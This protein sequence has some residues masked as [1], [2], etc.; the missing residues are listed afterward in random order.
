MKITENLVSDKYSGQLVGYID[1]GDP[2][3]N[4]ASF[5]DPDSLATHVLVFHI[6]GIAS[7]LKVTSAQKM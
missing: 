7:D 1:L 6:R 3:T 4:H 2:E 5:I